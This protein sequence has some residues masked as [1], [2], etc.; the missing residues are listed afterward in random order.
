M[1]AY[2]YAIELNRMNRNESNPN[3]N[4]NQNS[5]GALFGNALKAVNNQTDTK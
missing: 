5:A 3:I 1:A 2:K 4:S